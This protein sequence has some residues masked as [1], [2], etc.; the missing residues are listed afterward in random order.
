VPI[1]LSPIIYWTYGKFSTILGSINGTPCRG[2]AGK[3]DA[4]G[5][6]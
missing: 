1:K 2:L 5:T 4:N 6:R 3:A